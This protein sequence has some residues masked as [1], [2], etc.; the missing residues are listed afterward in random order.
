MDGG[1]FLV[2]VLLSLGGTVALYHAI[3]SETADPEVMDR[4]EAESIA[5]E[6][7]QRRAR[8]LGRRRDEPRSSARRTQ[9]GDRD[10]E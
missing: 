2:F 6:E 1:L 5:R 9:S 7:A 10:D 4:R 3:E 8:R